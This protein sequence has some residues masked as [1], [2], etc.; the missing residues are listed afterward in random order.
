MTDSS[1]IDED[2]LTRAFNDIVKCLDDTDDEHLISEGMQPISIFTTPEET[3]VTL[4]SCVNSDGILP[5]LLPKT[6][7]LSPS[8]KRTFDS[9]AVG[10]PSSASLASSPN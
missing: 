1:N 9:R 2:Q 6:R 7:S 8:H 10:G 4:F 5:G 3:G